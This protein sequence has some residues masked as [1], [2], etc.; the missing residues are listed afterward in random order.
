L[1][2]AVNGGVEELPALNGINLKLK[3]SGKELAEIGSLV[4]IDIPELGHFDASGKISGFAKSFSIDD[5]EV[6]VDNSDFKG[7]ARL[8]VL[9]RPK[10][11]V[12]LE[13]SVI[14]F[15]VKKILLIKI[16]NS[17]D[18]FRTLPCLWI[19]SRKWML[20]SC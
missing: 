5:F 1:N 18:C 17:A 6:L 12:R 20:I 9:K 3:V 14:D 2:L 19:S 7:R 15:T 10:L 13:S 8:E 16:S 4:G 11:T